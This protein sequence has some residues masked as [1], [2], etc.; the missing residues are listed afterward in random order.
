MPQAPNVDGLPIWLQIVLSFAFMVTSVAVAVRGYQ[1]GPKPAEPAVKAIASA[2]DIG[3]VRELVDVNHDLRAEI[4]Q[5]ARATNE[6][7][8]FL[9]EN[10]EIKREL[11]Q[12]LRELR[13]RI[14][15]MK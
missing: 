3:G 5:L 2:V 9:R 12:R 14:E 7:T 10:I 13:E 6:M 4:M 8:H 11:C 1:T 15:A